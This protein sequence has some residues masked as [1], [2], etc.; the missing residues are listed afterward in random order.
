MKDLIFACMLGPGESEQQALL[1]A[2]SLRTFAGRYCFDPIWMLS[3]RPEAD[4]SRVTREELITLGVRFVSF[5]PDPAQKP[6]PFLSYVTAAGIAEGLAQGQTSLLAML[7]ADTLVL[8]E[9]APFQLAAGKSFGGCPVHLKLLGSGSGEAVNEFWQLIYKHCRVDEGRIFSMS[10]LVDEQPVR[11]YF[12]AGALV[13]RPER[14]L[15]RS[16]QATFERLYPMPEFEAF[17]QQSELYEIFMHQAVLA[18]SLLA[19]LRPDEFQQFPLEVN[20]P[21]HLHS[22]MPKEL[23]PATL[24]ELITCRYEDYTETFSDPT[25]QVLLAS[26]KS[27]KDWLEAQFV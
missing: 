19:A 18:G 14:G 1:L 21:L 9:P 16:W 4:L 23:R 20:Y 8:Q 27:V 7:A 17:Y 25:V 10:T 26:S 11:A 15:L 12:N 5:E 13:V 3:T 6:F 22:R 2:R 24:E